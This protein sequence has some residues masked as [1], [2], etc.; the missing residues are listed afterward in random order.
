MAFTREQVMVVNRIG[1]LG[2]LCCAT[3][4]AAMTGCWGAWNAKDAPPS[5][6]QFRTETEFVPDAQIVKEDVSPDWEQGR[7][8][9][10]RGTDRVLVLTRYTSTV[11]V[12][13]SNNQPEV[14]SDKFKERAWIQVPA[15]IP[16]GQE[17]NVDELEKRFLLA[18]DNEER[19]KGMFVK[20]YRIAGRMT[21]LEEKDGNMIAFLD[22]LVTPHRDLPP[23]RVKGI[24]PMPITRS[25]INAR[26][27]VNALLKQQGGTPSTG[28]GGTSTPTST[29]P[30]SAA[31][32]APAA[33]SNPAPTAK[34]TTPVK[35]ADLAPA[36]SKSLVGKWAGDAGGYKYQF[37]FDNNT[38]FVFNSTK[39][40]ATG[41]RRGT[42]SLKGDYIVL[43][44]EHYDIGGADKLKTM[45]SPYVM[46]RVDWVNGGPSLSGDLKSEEGRVQIPLKTAD[47]P[48]MN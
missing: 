18:Y 21:L 23:W 26:P 45:T 10:I 44:I 46:L 30:S 11:D 15:D 35:A 41:I 20:P 34:T 17:I 32:G 27:A 7:Q 6:A 33:P 28:T 43:H 36:D 37:Q 38:R 29:A 2:A 22:I 8:A 47:F 39:G 1:R 40:G 16:L 9:F 12:P 24:T 5:T 4:I 14:R 19:G 3:M 13:M 31:P 42:Y 48:P 25:G